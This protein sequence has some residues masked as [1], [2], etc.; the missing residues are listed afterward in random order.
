MSGSGRKFAWLGHDDPSFEFVRAALAAGDVLRGIVSVPD[1]TPITGFDHVPRYSSVWQLLSEQSIHYVVTARPTDDG[2][3][4]KALLQA[5]SIDL[6]VAVPIAASPDIYHELGLI[7]KEA[8]S[9]YLPLMAELAHPVLDEVV[10]Q[11]GKRVEIRRLEYTQPLDPAAGLEG[12]F[13]L[14]WSWLH[15]VEG[16][17]ESVQATAAT[18]S[19]GNCRM[20]QVMA[21]FASGTLATLAWRADV[22]EHRFEIETAGRTIIA[23]LP[24]GFTGSGTVTNRGPAGEQVKRI[25]AAPMGER[26]FAKWQMMDPH[27]AEP[28]THALRQ[29]ELS[30]AVRRSL[31]RERAVSLEFDEFTEAAGFKSI[32]AATGCGLVWLT[33]LIAIL[34]AAGVPY[35]QYAI[36]PILVL[37][38]G[39][40]LFGLAYRQEETRS[41]GNGTSP[42]VEKRP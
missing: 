11:L 6:V 26:L 4:L 38:L 41:G 22:T 10:T 36:L 33:L 5:E 13:L 18:D 7:R 14:G 35:V 37:F 17:V 21:R 23:S 40:Q 12:R 2:Q 15:R 30:Q 28:W 1:Q 27:E 31:E 39:S 42:P 3:S 19:L 29:V 32:M 20:V 34:A 16:D 24:S 8:G 9:R 25:D